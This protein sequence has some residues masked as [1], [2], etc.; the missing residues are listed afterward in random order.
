MRKILTFVLAGFFLCSCKLQDERELE[1][2][3]DIDNGP[4]GIGLV[5]PSEHVSGWGRKDCLMCHNAALNIHRSAGSALN[6]DALNDE[7]ESNGESGY[8]LTCHGPNGVEE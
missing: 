6:V 7:I 4:G 2:Y 3:G 1:N 8:C 5:N